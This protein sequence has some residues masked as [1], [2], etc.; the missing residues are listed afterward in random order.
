MPDSVIPELPEK[1][2]VECGVKRPLVEELEGNEKIIQQSGSIAPPS[3]DV[4]ASWRAG[5]IIHRTQS[6]FNNELRDCEWQQIALIINK[7]V[8]KLARSS[9]AAAVRTSL[10]KGQSHTRFST[11]VFFIESSPTAYSSV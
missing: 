10:L 5:W 7:A 4:N 6:G 11:P 2:Y 9:T 8:Y 3:G 1:E